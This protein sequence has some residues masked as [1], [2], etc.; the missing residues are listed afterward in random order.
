MQTKISGRSVLIIGGGPAGISAAQWCCEL[1]LE[2]TLIESADEFGGQLL[3]IYNPINNYLGL[4]TANGLELRERFLAAVEPRPF[5]RRTSSPVTQLNTGDLVATLASGEVIKA[6]AIIL[7]TGV[8]RRKLRVA[9]EEMF[10]GKGILESGSR[11]KEQVAGKRVLIAGGGDAAIENALI[12]A[13]RASRVMVVHRRSEFSARKEFLDAARRHP[14]IEFITGDTIAEIGGI[15][16]VEFVG[17]QNSYTGKSYKILVDYVLTRIGVEPNSDLVLGK[18][19]MDNREYVLV[20][21]HCRTS[22]PGVFAA[23]DVASPVSPTISSAVGQGSAAAK[24]VFDL[25]MR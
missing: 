8:R 21:S 7:A 15:D 16:H 17:L 6:S 12:L 18:V 2:A 14:R 5:V 1:G 20:D 25:V 3:R 11:E 22:V 24:S 13:E 23:G 10:R 19:D 9:G 4:E